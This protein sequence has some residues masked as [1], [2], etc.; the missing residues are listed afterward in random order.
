MSNTETVGWN[1]VLY[2]DIFIG[3]MHKI[4]TLPA[5][6]SLDASPYPRIEC[7]YILMVYT[8]IDPCHMSSF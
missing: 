4:S 5:L 8:C 7:F 1:H 6:P 2:D 3:T